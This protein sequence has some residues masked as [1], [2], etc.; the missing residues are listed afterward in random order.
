MIQ[1]GP[2]I[3]IFGHLARMGYLETKDV[4]LVEAMVLRQQT[5]PEP[6]PQLI[7]INVRKKLL[8]PL[9]G[10]DVPIPFKG[11]VDKYWGSARKSFPKLTPKKVQKILEEVRS[12]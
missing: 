2:L 7:D 3:P 8:K 4:V 6:T 5:L 9:F 12:G 11:A 1:V 10:A